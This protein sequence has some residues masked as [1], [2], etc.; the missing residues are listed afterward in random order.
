MAVLAAEAGGDG[1]EGRHRGRA[2]RSVAVLAISLV[3]GPLLIGTELLRPVLAIPLLL[4]GLAWLWAL[5]RFLYPTAAPAARLR[6][7]AGP[8]ARLIGC[9]AWILPSGI[10]GVGACHWDYIKHNLV[11]GR[12]LAG[13]LPLA[14]GN[15]APFHYY[16]AYYILPVRLS[17]GIAALVP[18]VPLDLVLLVLYA[19]LLFLSVE[20]LAWGFRAPPGRLLLLLALTGGGLDLI[21]L[22]L[23]GGHLFR[24]GSVPGIGVPLLEGFE[25]WGSPQAPQAFTMHLYWAPQHLFAAL[26]GTALLAVLGRLSRPWPATLLHAGTVVAAAAFWSIYVAVGLALLVAGGVAWRILRPVGTPAQAVPWAPAAP[27]CLALAAFA[28][29]YILAARAAG[30]PPGLI[31]QTT[32][33]VIWLVSILLNHA[34]WI[35]A[36]L[37]VPASAVQTAERRTLAAMLGGGLAASMLLLCLRHGT[38][39]DWGMRTILPAGLLLSAATAR[40][41]GHGLRPLARLL[42]IALLALSSASS[43]AQIAQGLFAPWRCAPYGTYTEREL[44]PLL[45]QYEGDPESLLYRLLA[46]RQ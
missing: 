37:L 31:F 42:L 35:A 14:L 1:E 22:P 45:P 36:L 39:N 12:L 11:F 46:R 10:G 41:L 19:A 27:L 24:E 30:A 32:S 23:L 40:L 43:L 2:P 7:S 29:V 38:Y 4:A 8:L 18:W 44:G 33:P 6:L 34:P 21:G 16:F 20:M 17:Q 26:I 28:A 3:A 9:I 25:W 15:G 5:D 13:H